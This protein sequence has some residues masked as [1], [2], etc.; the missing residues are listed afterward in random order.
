[1]TLPLFRR[2]LLLAAMLGLVF[3]SVLPA[4][5]AQDRKRERTSYSE[6]EKIGFAFYRLADK[7]PPFNN[8]IMSR[9]EYLLAKPSAKRE[10]LRRE[11]ERLSKAYNEYMVDDDMIYLRTEV[12]IK[13]PNATERQSY[14]SM[15]LRKPVQIMLNEV[16]ENYFPVQIGEMWIAVVPNELDKY[17]FLS[18]EEEE[19]NKMMRELTLDTSRGAARNALLEIRLRPVSI[20]TKNP[21]HLDGID[22]WLMLGEI[23]SISLWRNKNRDALVWEQNMDWYIPQQQKD[24]LDLYSR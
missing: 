4:A 11:T 7:S 12:T 21:M 1:M 18:L 20:D 23:A 13:V 19:Y 10:Y 17:L 2:F 6:A 3:T 24:L 5:S 22:A 14:E 16:K 8:W 9:D 15:G